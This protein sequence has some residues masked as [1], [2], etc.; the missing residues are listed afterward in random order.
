MFGRVTVP[1]DVF[2][3]VHVRHSFGCPVVR[4]DLFTVLLCDGTT[5]VN[6]N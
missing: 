2:P 1:F 6:P 5:L 4:G 3:A